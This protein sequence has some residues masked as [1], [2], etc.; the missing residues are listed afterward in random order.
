MTTP[1]ALGVI[2][3]TVAE[4]GDTVLVGAGSVLDGETARAAILSGA[5]YVVSPITNPGMIEMAHRYDKVAIPG[6][7]T[8]T[9]ALN[10]YTAGADFV[11]IFPA[12][13]GG[14]AYIKAIKAPLPQLPL[15]PTGGVNLNTIQDFLK[16][17][18]DAV[19]VGSALVKKDALKA[20]DME[21]IRQTAAAFMEKVR[22]AAG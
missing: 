9:E 21:A 19:G 10:A 22:A 5:Q 16:A 1:G 3:K 8:P 4:L 14:P 17:G 12:D 15:V 11:K 6:A 18:A 20:G 13:V 7:Y 2:E